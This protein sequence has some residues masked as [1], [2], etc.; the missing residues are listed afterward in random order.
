MKDKKVPTEL[1]WLCPSSPTYQKLVK[2]YGK[3]KNKRR[4]EKV[5]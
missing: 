5:I 4:T 2:E 1:M 3:D